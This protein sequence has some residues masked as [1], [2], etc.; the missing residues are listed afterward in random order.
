MSTLDEDSESRWVSR[1]SFEFELPFANGAQI[2]SLETST[3]AIAV[4]DVLT[5]RDPCEILK[6]GQANGTHVVV[7]FQFF[8]RGVSVTS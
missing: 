5:W 4:K 2:G 1:C 8:T 6:F 7:F 3:E